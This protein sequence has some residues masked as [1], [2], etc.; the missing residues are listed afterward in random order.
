MVSLHRFRQVAALADDAS[1]LGPL[2][3][4]LADV[5]RPALGEPFA[6]FGHSVGALISFELARELDKD[7]QED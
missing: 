3:R 2:I 5:L 7:P 1:A 6:F 4:T